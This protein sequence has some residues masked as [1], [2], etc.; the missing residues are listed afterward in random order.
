M[1]FAVG[2]GWGQSLPATLPPSVTY[3]LNPGVLVLGQLSHQL[4]RTERLA[5]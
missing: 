1:Q 5:L 4:S 3:H 2:K